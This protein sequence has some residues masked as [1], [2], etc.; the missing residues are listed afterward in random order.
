MAVEETVSGAS[1]ANVGLGNDRH[2]DSEN[3]HLVD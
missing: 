2:N 3:I 1:V